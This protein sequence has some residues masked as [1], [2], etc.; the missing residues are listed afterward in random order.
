MKSKPTLDQVLT[1]TFLAG[2]LTPD[3]CRVYVRLFI[4]YADR[5][6]TTRMQLTSVVINGSRHNS[7]REWF[8]DEQM[9][10]LCG[11]NAC[12]HAAVY[13]YVRDNQHLFVK[14]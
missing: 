6:T 13:R 1:E 12:I 7:I 14:D 10:N 9:D 8:T 3:F 4:K 11:A 5:M 2:E